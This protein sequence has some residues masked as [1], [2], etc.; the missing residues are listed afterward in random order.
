M[1]QMNTYIDLNDNQDW[2]LVNL[3]S[4]LQQ[5][6]ERLK[7][8]YF[9]MWSKKINYIVKW[10][11]G[12][13]ISNNSSFMIFEAAKEVLISTNAMN[14]P[15]IQLVSVL[16]HVMIHLY[17][18]VTSKGAIKLNLHDDNFREIMLYLNDL[19]STQ[20]SVGKTNCFIMFC[21]F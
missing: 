16:L 20:I 19:L 17:L 15:R 12:G 7:D 6:F 10:D 14:R 4:N 2:T 5:M 3:E 11:T 18:N 8:Q 21:Q 9:K 13:V 1:P